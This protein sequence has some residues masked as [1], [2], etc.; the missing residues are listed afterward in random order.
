MLAGSDVSFSGSSNDGDMADGEHHSAPVYLWLEREID[1]GRAGK[2]TG[3]SQGGGG[4][5]WLARER[6]PN[7]ESMS[8]SFAGRRRRR[9]RW[10][11]RGAPG[12]SI[13]C[14][15]SSKAWRS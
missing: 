14:L 12:L 8:E 6:L 13:L 11:C 4:T 10:R 3:G 1:M 7:N 15:G 5:G 9:W 2:T